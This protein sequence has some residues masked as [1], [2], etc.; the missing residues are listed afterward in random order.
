MAADRNRDQEVAQDLC[1]RFEEVYLHRGHVD[2]MAHA[3]RLEDYYLAGGKQWTDT[4]REAMENGDNPRP[5]FE[6]DIV[7]P[8]VNAIAGY[9]IANRV[10]LSFVPRGGDADAQKAKLLSKVVRQVLDNSKWRFRETE[11]FLDGLIQ[12]RGYIDVRMDYQRND[13]GEVAL[14]VIDPLDGIPDPDA[15]SYDPDDWL[16]WHEARWLTLDQIE[17]D[18]GKQAADAVKA[19]A[20]DASTS[21]PLG[22]EQGV[23]RKGFGDRSNL[24]N[25]Y[26]YGYYGEGAWRRYRIVHRQ[27][28]EF[29]KVL[30]AR[31]PTGDIRVVEN[32]AREGIAWLLQQGIPVFKRRMRRTRMQVFAPNV[33]LHDERSPYNHITAVP[34]FPYFRRGRTVGAID[35]LTS[36]Q[37]MLN[38]FTSQ[39]AHIVN[40]TANSGWQG[41]ADSLEN[42]DDDQLAEEGGKTGLL[43]LRKP[44]M[45]ELKKIEP[46]QVPTGIDRMVEFAYK[47]G[48]IVS[49]VDENML[50]L[51]KDLSGVAVQ[52]LQYAAQQKLAIVLNNLSL[53]RRMVIERT[54]ENTQQ[55]MGAERVL[56]IAEDDAFGIKQHVP[57]VLNQRQDDGSVLNDLTVGTYDL[58][59]NEQPAQV[60]F[61]NSQFEQMKALRKDMAIPISDARVVRSSNLLDKS[62]IAEEL[63]RNSGK[64]DPVAEAEAALSQAMARK[65]AAEAVNKAIEA[66]FSAVKT[67]REIVMTPA[68]AALADALLRSGGY[69]DQDAAPIIPE[70]PAGAVVPPLNE[71]EN[72]HPLAPPN[73]ERGLDAGMESTSTENVT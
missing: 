31:W 24:M 14:R 61:D 19:S 69:Q 65:A 16:D 72:T 53:T 21:Y 1:G 58:V 18:Y 62:E 32:M 28:N 71:A 22:S 25:T 2:W 52:S 29:D 44:G 4:D 9:Q 7:K 33:L 26:G 37:D 43:L 17:A 30:V 68:A 46:N 40:T 27:V 45:P 15:T 20:A 63:E 55:F 41:Q 10:D 64:P 8:A 70:P 60:T 23:Q 48:Q 5:C 35:S 11:A 36:V 54:L 67:A 57:Y 50:G 51:Q 6:V 73:P 38:K 39:F 13:L 56:R 66:Q 49:G 12:Q 3:M 59:L 47:N 34:F 42:M